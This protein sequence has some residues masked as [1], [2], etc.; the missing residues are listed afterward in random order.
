MSTLAVLAFFGTMALGLLGWAIG[1][2][3]EREFWDD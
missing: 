3:L 1:M 2:Y